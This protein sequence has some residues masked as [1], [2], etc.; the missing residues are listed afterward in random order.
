MLWPGFKMKQ[1]RGVLRRA[2][3]SDSQRKGLEHAF[4][5]QKYI[6]K[7]DRKKLAARLGLKDSQVKIWFQNRRMKWRNSKEREMMK[8]KNNTQTQQQQQKSPEILNSNTSS[9]G[10]KFSD[11][12]QQQQHHSS[13]SRDSLIFLNQNNL[14]NNPKINLNFCSKKNNN[15]NGSQNNLVSEA[16][17]LNSS[18]VSSSSST[19]SNSGKNIYDSKLSHNH[20]SGDEGHDDQDHEEIDIENNFDDQSEVSSSG[21]EDEE[22]VVDDDLSIDLSNDQEDDEASENQH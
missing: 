21:N 14:L 2:V 16:E 7:P 12:Q 11:S 13:I 4:V 6:S 3:F 9:S 15:G 10:Y 17:S 19:S 20:I 18:I 5:K 8:S 22:D 1:R